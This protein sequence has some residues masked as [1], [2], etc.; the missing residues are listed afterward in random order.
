V[1]E[2]V[3]QLLRGEASAPGSLARP[4]GAAAYSALLPTIWSLL[5]SE[6]STAEDGAVLPVVVEHA[7]KAGSTSAVKRSTIDFLGRLVLL[8]RETEYA[9]TCRV[10]RAAADDQ[11]LEE[12][13]LHLAQT[14]WEL[15]ASSLPTT[16][17]ILRVFLRVCQRRSPLVR[18]Q[19]LLALRSRM[20]PYF[21]VNHPTRGR[22]LGPFA[23]LPSAPLRRLVLDVVATIEW[24]EAD[25]FEGDVSEAVRGTEEESYWATLVSR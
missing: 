9:G 10:G 1:S 25:G 5:N 16:E 13:L 23:R 4:V 24:Q 14:L 7:M 21:I 22:L 11:R 15:G 8:E 2:Y 18:D 20:V 19:V 3:V 17:T 12:W 6:A